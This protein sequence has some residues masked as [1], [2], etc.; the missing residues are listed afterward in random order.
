MK[1]DVARGYLKGP[2]SGSSAYIFSRG[3]MRA[4][5]S[6]AAVNVTR[7]L[8]VTCDYMIVLAE[9]FYLKLLPHPW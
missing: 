3:G 1:A 8:P 2:A 7:F 9:V 4:S 5:R 6:S